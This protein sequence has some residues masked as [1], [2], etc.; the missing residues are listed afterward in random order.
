MIEDAELLR[1]SLVQG[2]REAGYQVDEAADGDDG[3]RLSLARPYDL[4]VLDLMLPGVDGMAIL[5]RVRQHQ[6]GVRA[7]GGGAVGRGD[8]G[9]THV[10]ILTARDTAHDRVAGLDG[11]ADDYLVKPFAFPEL[12]ARV[13]AL[14]RRKGSGRPSVISVG[15]L[16][17]D[18]TARTVKRAGR[19]VAVSAREYALI[20]LLARR[21]GQVVTRAE[22][23]RHVYDQPAADS[24]VVDVFVGNLRRK[25]ERSDLPR[26]LHT[27]R[28]QGYMLA[29][30]GGETAAAGDAQETS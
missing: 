29:V 4:I 30:P 14:L 10:L 5:Q 17:V 24:N 8:G 3:L 15:D 18:T 26:L 25:I 27:R 22:I 6:Q 28:G 9:G 7:G 23:C 2:L 20:E 21:A 19:D 16:E 12:L 11:G 1:Q 13:R